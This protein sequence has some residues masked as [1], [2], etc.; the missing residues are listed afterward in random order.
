[1]Q[2]NGKKVDVLEWLRETGGA[3]AVKRFSAEQS[4]S[5]KKSDKATLSKDDAAALKSQMQIAKAAVIPGANTDAIS[6]YLAQLKALESATKAT[7]TKDTNTVAFT[8]PT[9]NSASTKGINNTVDFQSTMGVVNNNTVAVTGNGNI[10]RGFSGG[11]KNNTMTV[12][13][14]T[15]RIY[16]GQS[17]SNTT[18]SVKGG[19]NSVTLSENASNNNITI[20][21]NNV[22]VA[23][24][25]AGLEPGSNQNWTISVAADNVEVSVVNGKASVNM[26]QGMEDKYKVTIDNAKKTV[27][28]TAV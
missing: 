7:V 26:A 23:V 10:V 2:V 12:T 14:D 16:A 8:T 1:M 4:S 19:N 21:G 9:T 15:N 18:M 11:Q 13:G 25:T 27:S 3:N 22:K 20:S 6:S 5:V 24:G 28:V 17:V